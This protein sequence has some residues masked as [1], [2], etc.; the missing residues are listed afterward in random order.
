MAMKIRTFLFAFFMALFVMAGAN[1][2]LGYF[3]GNAERKIEVLRNDRNELSIIAEDFIVSSQWACRFARTFIATLEPKRLKYYS[4]IGDIVDGQIERPSN[5]SFAYWDLVAG[6]LIPPPSTDSKGHSIEERF[7]KADASADEIEALSRAQAISKKVSLIEATAMH[8]V[9]GEFL[10]NNGTFTKK[11][12]PNAELAKSLIYSKE[13]NRD[14]AEL[15]QSILSVKEMISKRYAATMERQQS[16]VDALLRANDI[17]GMLLIGLIVVSLIKLRQILGSLK[18]VADGVSIGGVQLASA[19]RQVLTAA[20]DQASSM[21]ETAAAMEQMAAAIRQNANASSTTL[22]TSARVADDAR[23]CA[24]EMQRTAAAMKGIVEK[25]VA[26]EDI[27]RKIELLALN[28]AVEAARAGEYGKGFAV[29]AAEVSK[30]A[31][32]SKDSTSAIQQ[33]S[34]EGREAAERTDR[35]LTSLLP[36]IEKAKDLVKG[37]QIASEEQ[38]T[39]AQQVNDAMRR[40]DDVIQ[41]NAN[42]AAQVSSIASDLADHARKLQSEIGAVQRNELAE[43][44]FAASLQNSASKLEGEEFGKY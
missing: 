41:S 29:V 34:M 24:H 44:T 25:S 28:A 21:Q 30:L 7:R 17:L 6:E 37:I 5:Y 39:G 11:A 15:S 4:L 33:S 22:A 13:Y 38:A 26:V 16:V 10:D 20:N 36:D 40:L 19:G 18:A 31:D 35:M 23:T 27:T 9:V 2:I 12:K 3:L 42:A 14:K 43:S 1:L 8:A 32:L